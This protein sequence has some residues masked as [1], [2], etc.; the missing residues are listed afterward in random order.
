MGN[1]GV[2]FMEKTN[3]DGKTNLE[4]QKMG[5]RSSIKSK[6]KNV[7]KIIELPHFNEI[8]LKNIRVNGI[9][10]TPKSIIKYKEEPISLEE[11]SYI[12]WSTQ[13]IKQA[14][15]GKLNIINKPS[16]GSIDV[17]ETY[18]LVNNVEGLKKGLYGFIA[19]ENKLFEISIKKNLDE[20]IVEACYGQ[21]AVKNCAVT[22]ICT[23]VQQ[24]ILCRYGER[25][26]RYLN[27]DAG[28]V[29]QNLYLAANSIECGVCAVAAYDDD[30]L[31]SILGIDGVDQFAIYIATV[32]KK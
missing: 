9:I 31:N 14:N 30:E 32:G 2:K 28:H 8:N 19:E 16:L 24:K 12:L 11:L 7:G 20:E 29:C 5:V 3:Y 26:Y 22:F 27:L 18:L 25:G 17:F 13:G 21:T 15:Q 23:A 6:H 4:R 10:N 1:I